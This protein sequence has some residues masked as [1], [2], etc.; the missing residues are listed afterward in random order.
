MHR[1][2]LFGEPTVTYYGFAGAIASHRRTGKKFSGNSVDY[3]TASPLLP[4]WAVSSF[5]R[6]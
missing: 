1:R 5:T 2:W 6:N 3:E 4:T